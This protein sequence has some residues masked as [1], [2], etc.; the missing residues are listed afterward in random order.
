GWHFEDAGS[1]LPFVEVSRRSARGARR[2]GANATEPGHPAAL[3]AP[4]IGREPLAAD[5]ADLLDPAHGL[6]DTAGR[7]GRDV[8][9]LDV[10]EV[11]P[12]VVPLLEDLLEI[13]VPPGLTGLLELLHDVLHLVGV[14]VDRD[15][16]DGTEE[17][18]VLGH[19]DPL[20]AVGHE[21][22]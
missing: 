11:F 1:L 2:P 17:R 20:A 19:D 3:R 21:L 6:E 12:Q 18:E 15:T 10:L 16:I 4:A 13:V 8:E 9:D 22:G 5:L 14:G 7:C